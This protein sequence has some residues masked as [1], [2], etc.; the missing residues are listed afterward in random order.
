MSLKKILSIVAI[1]IVAVIAG[2]II[3]ISLSYSSLVKAGVEEY[4]PRY[5]QTT[6]ELGGVSASLFG[7]EITIDDFLIGN[8]EGHKT[9]HAFKVASVNVDADMSSLTG[10]TIR[11][12]EVVIE[13]P[14]IIYELGDGGSNLETI[15]NNVSKA[16]GGDQAKAADS[17][18]G[19]GPKVVIDNLYIRN[20]KVAL[21]A[22][23]LGGETVPVPV[24]DIHL[25]D[26]GKDSKEGGGASI[27]DA[28]KLVM[29]ELTGSI[30][31]A[32]SSINLDDV[33]KQFE[34]VTK[35]ADDATKGVTDEI[36]GLFGK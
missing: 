17:G 36:K 32:A 15:Q 25:K 29:D 2:A 10:D 11:I 8:P 30:A 5:T 1:A 20:V 7:G 13:A 19:E 34:G 21:S 9:S 28:A 24:P 3:Y 35:G 12:T 27:A 14:D 16:A 31:K 33:K 23:M 26:I 18:G 22:G 6:V 4:G